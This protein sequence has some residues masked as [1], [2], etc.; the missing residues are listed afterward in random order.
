MK[1]IQIGL[2]PLGRK[3]ARYISERSGIEMAGAA[4]INPEFIGQDVGEIC[5]TGPLGVTVKSTIMEAIE[6]CDADC[7]ILTTVSSLQIITPQI[8]EVVGHGLPVVSTSEELLHPWK[9]EP[10]LASRIDAAAKASNAGVLGTGINPG[11]LMDSLP[12]FLTAVCQRVDSV[13]VSRLQDASFRREPFQ[14]KIG[15]GLALGE[16]EALVAEKKIRHVGLAESIHLIAD[17]LGWEL[18]QVEDIISPVIAESPVESNLIQ[19]PAGGVAGVQQIGKGLVGNEEKIT[20]VF[21]A[22]IGETDPGDTIEIEGDPNIKSTI[23]QGVNGDI[24]TCAMTIN[25]VKQVIRARPGLQ[26]IADIPLVT[27]FS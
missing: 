4:D 22:S 15:A 20:L 16:F 11:F 26:T 24:G 14:R 13:K 18:D 19:V 7:A 21:R 5:G 6:S 27:H 1:V 9:T 3:I 2:G 25:A 10:E 17:S 8:L 12:L 23:D